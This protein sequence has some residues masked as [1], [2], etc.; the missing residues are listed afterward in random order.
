MRL[1]TA[2]FTALLTLQAATPASGYSR[3]DFCEALL[4]LVDAAVGRFD[5][6]RSTTAT[7]YVDGVPY[8][9]SLRTLPDAR[10]CTISVDANPVLSCEFYTGIMPRAEELYERL[11]VD[12]PQ[13]IEKRVAGPIRPV[14]EDATRT[15]YMTD[16]NVQLDVAN[17]DLFGEVLHLR[18]YIPAT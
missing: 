5:S 4:A 17:D 10:M 11:N 12:V 2:T 16:N 7:F 6:V 1:A 15:S 3:K 18:M 14:F 8:F 9:L 13:C